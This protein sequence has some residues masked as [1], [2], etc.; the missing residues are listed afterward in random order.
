MTHVRKLQQSPGATADDALAPEIEIVSGVEAAPRVGRYT[1]IRQLGRGACADVFLARADGPAGFE[2]RVALKVLRREMTRDQQ[3]VEQFLA[4][5]R[6]AS[7]LSH[8]NIVATL[9]LGMGDDYFIA[10]E[11]VDGTDL[12]RLG[13]TLRRLG[14]Q[15]PVAVA[16]TIVRRVCDGLHAAHTAVDAR[17]ESLRVV[18]RDIKPANVFLARNGMIKIGDFGVARAQQLNRPQL[19]TFGMVKG[20]TQFM[21]PEQRTGE[22]FAIDSLHRLTTT[23]PRLWPVST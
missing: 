15:M 4:E 12:W 10:M 14:Q 18:H 22:R 13:E 1:I 20:T 19:T 6:L 8:P 3:I 11:L 9:D 5:A 2:K 23:L 17:G 21:P 7:E 16:L